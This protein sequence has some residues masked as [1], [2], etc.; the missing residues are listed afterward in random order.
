M[1][2]HVEQGTKGDPKT[3]RPAEDETVVP[4]TVNVPARRAG[5]E[6]THVSGVSGRVPGEKVLVSPGEDTVTDAPRP[7]GGQMEASYEE[8]LAYHR[9]RLHDPLA[10]Q[11]IEGLVNTSPQIRAHLES[12]RFLDLERAA[13]TQDAA[14]LG[15]FDAA[16][17]DPM[18]EESAFTEGVVFQQ[19][20]TAETRKGWARHA[21]TCVFCRRMQRQ[22]LARV[23]ARRAGLP[24]GQVLLVNWLLDHHYSRLLAA[25]AQAIRNRY[26]L[27]ALPP[28]L[29]EPAEKHLRGV[30]VEQIAAE[31]NLTAGAVRERLD[32]AQRLMAEAADRRKAQLSGRAR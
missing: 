12:V 11:R 21:R 13:A 25:V 26:T 6:E 14:D 31:T 24:D 16:Q 5:D 30:S 22:V 28:H 17:A 3:G 27:S 10:L 29:R 32:E 15:R 1:G 7:N 18:C 9:G 19:G 2:K 23:E 8:L 4:G 20:A